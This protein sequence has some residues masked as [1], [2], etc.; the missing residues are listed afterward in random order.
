ML[1]DARP[2][3]F[4]RRRLADDVAAHRRCESGGG[5][6]EVRSLAPTAIAARARRQWRCQFSSRS[7][8]IEERLR[9]V[10][11]R[12]SDDWSQQT[13]IRYR[14][15]VHRLHGGSTNTSCTW[16]T[17]RQVGCGCRGCRYRHVTVTTWFIYNAGTSV[18]M[19]LLPPSRHLWIQ[20]RSPCPRRPALLHS[21]T[22]RALSHHC[23][24][25]VAILLNKRYSDLVLFGPPSPL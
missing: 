23:W 25:V 3:A 14:R 20:S 19:L 11:M 7:H 18:V 16:V 1:Q 15:R 22:A 24:P 5:A 13:V 10:W 17:A 4:S 8:F 21:I 6:A 9:G 2:P 12:Q